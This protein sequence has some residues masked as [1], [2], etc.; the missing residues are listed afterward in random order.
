MM[1]PTAIANNISVLEKHAGI[2]NE[3]RIQFVDLR[4][5]V[6]RLETIALVQG[7]SR[8]TEEAAPH[9]MTDLALRDRIT[10]LEQALLIIKGTLEEVEL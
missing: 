5:R 6:E 4:Q 9:E 10:A 2:L 7:G 3:H 1:N 8:P